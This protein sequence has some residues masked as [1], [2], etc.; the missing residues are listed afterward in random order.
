MCAVTLNL[1]STCYLANADCA[2][3]QYESLLTGYHVLRRLL[4]PLS[5]KGLLL[6]LRLRLGH[7]ERGML[8]VNGWLTDSYAWAVE[9]CRWKGWTAG[10]AVMV[11]G[12]PSDKGKMAVRFTERPW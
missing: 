11:K 6:D 9:V 1:V 12:S 5:P 3:W 4:L 2:P 10:D 8:S 7:N